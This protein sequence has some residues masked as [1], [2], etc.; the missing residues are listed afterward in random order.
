MSAKGA[1]G[2]GRACE[3]QTART[4]ALSASDAS[5]QQGPRNPSKAMPR[6]WFNDKAT[7]FQDQ[8]LP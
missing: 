3:R 7:C 1:I 2:A 8:W 6:R 4:A 5:K